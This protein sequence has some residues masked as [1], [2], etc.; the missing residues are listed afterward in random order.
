MGGLARDGL[1]IGPHA[2]PT[3]VKPCKSR[4]I[5]ANEKRAGWHFLPIGYDFWRARRRPRSIWH[6][7]FSRLTPGLINGVSSLWSRS[8]SGSHADSQYEIGTKTP[9]CSNGIDGRLGVKVAIVQAYEIFVFL[10]Y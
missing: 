3:P 7:T 6:R 5:A 9:Q 10:P 1:L 8:A 4:Q 2:F